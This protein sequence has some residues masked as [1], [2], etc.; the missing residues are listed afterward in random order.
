MSRVAINRLQAISLCLMFSMAVII[1]LALWGLILEQ[2]S[3]VRAV[4]QGTVVCDAEFGTVDELRDAAGEAGFGFVE[5]TPY[6]TDAYLAA[7]DRG[8][9]PGSE[10]MSAVITVSPSGGAML[11]LVRDGVLCSPALRITP[12]THSRAIGNAA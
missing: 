8:R 7:V 10:G 1:G 11:S 9:P 2:K 4:A 3:V 5:M 6:S 12:A